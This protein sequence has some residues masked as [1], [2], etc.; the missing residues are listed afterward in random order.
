[1]NRGAIEV[2]LVARN[3]VLQVL[4]KAFRDEPTADSIRMLADENV[5]D[6]F[7]FLLDDDE[8]LAQYQALVDTVRDADTSD[9]K[10]ADFVEHAKDEYTHFFTGPGHLEAPFWESIYLDDREML[11]LESTSAVRKAYRED[12]FEVNSGVHE[13]E[14]S[15]FLQLDYLSHMTTRALGLISTASK[16]Q[17]RKSGAKLSDKL[18]SEHNGDRCN[19]SGDSAKFGRVIARQETFE[20]NHMLD[21]LPQFAER[22]ANASTHHLY[23]Q[24]AQIA[25][26]FV[27]CDAKSLS[28][29]KDA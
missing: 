10:L 20:R 19:E 16:A 23:P 17:D 21:W 1:M 24:L 25:S 5:S 29:M 22:A 27:E 28:S 26:S 3:L 8:A 7:E 15:I 14:D 13:A 4:C 12:G 6:A 11:F 9:E 18:A 2:T